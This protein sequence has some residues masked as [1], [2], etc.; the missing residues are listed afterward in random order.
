MTKL[1]RII[2]QILSERQRTVNQVRA[3]RET[4]RAANQKTKHYLDEFDSIYQRIE[5]LDQIR[6]EFVGWADQQTIDDARG[7]ITDGEG[8]YQ[9]LLQKASSAYQRFREEG[10]DSQAAFDKGTTDF[11]HWIQT[12]YDKKGEGT[13]YLNHSPN[14]L[15][16]LEKMSW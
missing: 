15:R 4:E 16:R 11:T 2:N 10:Y 14:F 9:H 5:A 7:E 3:Q 12:S 13:I 6:R 8:F 1:Q